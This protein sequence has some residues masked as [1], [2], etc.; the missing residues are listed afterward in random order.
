MAECDWQRVLQT[1]GMQY[2]NDTLTSVVLRDCDTDTHIH[3]HTYIHAH[4]LQ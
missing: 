3:T 2:D 1:I 4:L